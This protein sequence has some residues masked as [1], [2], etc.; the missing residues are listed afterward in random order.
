MR[1]FELW[2]LRLLF[3]PLF[4]KLGH[5]F[6]PLQQRGRKTLE[7]LISVIFW[8]PGSIDKNHFFLTCQ[9]FWT[10]INWSR[11]CPKGKTDK[12]TVIIIRVLISKCQ[13]RLHFW[14]EDDFQMV[15][16]LFIDYIELS[17]WTKIFSKF[18]PQVKA[19]LLLKSSI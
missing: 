1:W 5:W 19:Y 7:S 15:I 8:V 12:C 14:S 3:D 9:N 17:Y 16:I 4:I 6:A 10:E 18:S 13:Q 2:A 11:K